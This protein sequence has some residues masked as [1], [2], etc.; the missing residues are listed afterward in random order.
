MELPSGR[1]LSYPG[2][3]VSV[4]KE[5]DEDG[6]VNTNVRIKYQGENQLTRQWG[7]PCTPTAAKLC[8]NI[9]FRRCAVICWLYA[10]D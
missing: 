3:G 8:E 9:A 6:R 10:T 1:I 7:L 5:T 2:I 4:T